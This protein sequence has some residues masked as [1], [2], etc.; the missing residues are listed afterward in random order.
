MSTP[1]VCIKIGGRVAADNDALSLF[2]VELV[3]LRHRYRFVLIHGGGV[4]V[5]RI[6]RRFHVEPVFMDGV[7]MTSPEEM[8]IVDM[9]LAG[10]VNKQLVRYL[11]GMGIPAVGLSGADGGLLIGEPVKAGTRTGKPKSVDPTVIQ[12]LMREGYMP[13]LSPV[14]MDAGGLGLNIN[15]DDAA[16]AI[17]VALSAPLLIFISDIPGILKSDE[18]VPR[19]RPDEA[20]REIESGIISGGMIP[21]VRASAGALKKGVGGVVIGGYDEAGDLLSLIE[22]KC[23]TKIYMQEAIHEHN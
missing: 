18:V 9:V 23:G 2:A 6:S 12:A 17:A 1:T 16:L 13:V 4:E 10:K 7:R 22:G 15:A 21:K 5:S 19:M 20:E 3:E 11:F 14:A 8:D